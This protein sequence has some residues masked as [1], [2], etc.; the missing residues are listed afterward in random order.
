MLTCPGIW[1]QPWGR[2]VLVGMG[3][4]AQVWELIVGRLRAQFYLG[5]ETTPAPGQ[6]LRYLTAGSSHTP[7]LGIDWGI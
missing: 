1:V 3:S 2:V 6:P 4:V 7:E 5:G